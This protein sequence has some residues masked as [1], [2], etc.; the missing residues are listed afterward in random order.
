V[1]RLML[2]MAVAVAF[3]GAGSALLASPAAAGGVDRS[4]GVLSAAVYNVTPYTWTLVAARSFMNTGAD[5]GA[6][7]TT[8]AATIAPG[9]AS[10]YGMNSNAYLDCLGNSLSWYGYDS[11]FTYQVDVLGGPSE[12]LTVAITG[13]DSTGGCAP[14]WSQQYAGAAVYITS[15]QPASNWDPATGN[16]PGPA[17][18]NQQ[19]NYQHNVPTLYDQTFVVNGNWTVDASTTL[20]RAFDDVLNQVCNVGTPPPANSPCEFTQTGPLIWGAGAP[21]TTGPTYNCNDPSPSDP[22][23]LLDITYAADSSA[24]LSAGGGLSVAT[25]GSLF[26]IVATTVTVEVDAQKEWTT[27]TSFSRTASAYIPRGSSG[28]IWTAPV[29]ATVAGTLV[30]KTGAATFTV[31]NFTETRSGVTKDNETPA[32]AD[33]VLVQPMSSAS[34]QQNCSRS[35]STSATAGA[36]RALFPGRGVERVR[37]GQRREVRRLGRPLIK[38]PRA[39]RSATSNDCRVLDPRCRMMPGRG[40]TWVYDGGLDVVFGADRRVSALIYSGR[41]RS[42]S[43]VGVGSSLRAV[44]AAYPGASC[45]GYPGGS[46]CTLK[47]TYRSRAVNTVFHFTTEKGRLKCHRVLMYFVDQRNGETSA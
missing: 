1:R 33:T 23:D 36:K 37:L 45:L 9:G 4:S 2:S 28:T 46:N 10:G 32:Y 19:I 7:Q 20:G 31:T 18:A 11:Y 3:S 41:G 34:L 40:G 5:A 43:G 35:A 24:S 6:L 38:S 25:E 8:P 30:V 12:Y 15:N 27:G 42:A 17:P 21:S 16:A 26:G 47:S 39:N 13:A 22:A 29:I 14:Y 44:G